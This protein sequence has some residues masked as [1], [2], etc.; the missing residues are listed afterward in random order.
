MRSAIL[1]DIHSNLQALQQAL[2]LANSFK[3]DR[4]FCLGDIVGYGANPNEC[5]DLVRKHCDTVVRG[6]HDLATVDLSHSWFHPEEARV[7]NAW[8]LKKLRGENR[9]YLAWL[10]F[11]HDEEGYTLV[12][13]SPESPLDWDRI[14]SRESAARQ[15]S[16][17]P[18]GVCFVGHTHIPFVLGEDLFSSKLKRGMKFLINVGSVG[19]PRDGNP[20]LSF[21]VFDTEAWTYESIRSPY[22]VQGAMNAIIAAGL[23]AGLGERLMTGV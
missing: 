14:Q 17:F 20:E 11:R 19:Q 13:A 4:I 1:S 2:S 3:V 10:P 6:N 9:R 18:A 22:D 15:F 5:V 12:H 8:T 21:G 7:V 23:P 16:H